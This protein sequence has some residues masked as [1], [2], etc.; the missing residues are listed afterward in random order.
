M[1]KKYYDMRKVGARC[2]KR[3]HSLDEA[4][5]L[6]PVWEFIDHKEIKLHKSSP[7][8]VTPIETPTIVEPVVESEK[9]YDKMSKPE[10]K[11]ALE[12]IAR[13]HGIELDKRKKLED[14]EEIVDQL[15]G[16]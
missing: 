16:E 1:K 5:S 8:K 13:E 6:R 10:K 11:D 7:K 12:I 15:L 4:L 3:I 14:L 2:S 9:E